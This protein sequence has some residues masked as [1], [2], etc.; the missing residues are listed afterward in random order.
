MGDFT[1][2]DLIHHLGHLGRAMCVARWQVQE[3][4]AATSA[5]A[6]VHH[7]AGLQLD[8]RQDQRLPGCLPSRYA[9]SPSQAW[10]VNINKGTYKTEGCTSRF[11]IRAGDFST[12]L[13]LQAKK[14]EAPWHFGYCLTQYSTTAR[15]E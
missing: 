10:P 2:L 4:I 1:L 9:G 6:E 7:H 11:L 13:A 14:E 15:P 12:A 3:A 8:R 5:G